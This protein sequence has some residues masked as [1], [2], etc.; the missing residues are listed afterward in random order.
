MNQQE[1]EAPPDRMIDRCPLCSIRV[2][3]GLEK[4]LPHL[5]K[6]HKRTSTEAEAL[7]GK[8]NP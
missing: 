8:Y 6:D 1:K 3:A 5:V 4:L 2:G 7:V